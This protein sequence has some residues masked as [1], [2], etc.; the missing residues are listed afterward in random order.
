MPTPE[1]IRT[2]TGRGRLYDSILDT[3]GDTPAI[4]INKLGAEHVTIYVKAEFFNPAASVKDRLARQHHRGGRA[5]RHA[6]ARPDRGRGDQRQ[7]RHRAR[8]GLRAEGLSA[9]RHDGRQLLDRAA[10]AD[11]HARREGRADAAGPEGLRHVPARPS[12]S[13]RPTAGSSP[14]SSR[15]RPTPRSTRRRRR[16]RSSPTSPAS[17]STTSSPATAPAAPWPAWRGCCARSGRRPRSSCPSPPTPSSSAA[18]P[19]RSARPTA[20]PRPAIRPSSRIR[21]RAGRRTSSRWCCRKR[22][23]GSYYDELIPVAGADGIKWAQRAGAEGGHLHRRLRRLDLR[24]RTCRWPSGPRR[25][26]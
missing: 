19:P 24:R 16:A 3:I 10:Q 5:Q 26:R 4:R 12:N 20:R 18:A 7:H 17:G 9:G 13:R 6:Q 8:D 14:T 22:S 2:T 1:S 23:T 15:P 25:A 11:A 21:S